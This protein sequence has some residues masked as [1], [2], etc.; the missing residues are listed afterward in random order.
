MRALCGAIITAGA[1]IGLGLT[2]SGIGNRYSTIRMTDAAGNLLHRD[3]A[4]QIVPASDPNSVGV[5]GLYLGEMD[6]GLAIVLVVLLITLIIGLATA[7]IGLMYHH[8]RRHHEMFRSN[9][10]TAAPEVRRSL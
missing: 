5:M 10:T 7:F 2:A 6:R 1:L 4:G 9:G 3:R 8:Y